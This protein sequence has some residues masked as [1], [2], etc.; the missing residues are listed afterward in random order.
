ML[1]KFLLWFKWT[2]RPRY[3]GILFKL[4]YSGKR[5]K[6]GKN[7]KCDKM[8]ELLITQKGKLSI[9]DNVTFK[10]N[11]EIRV[12]NNAVIEIGS[13]I[14]IDRGVRL[15][16]TNDAKTKISDGTRIGCYSI[17]NGGD[18]ITIGKKI[19]ISG[20]V[21]LQTSQHNFEKTD[22]IQSQGYSHAPITLGDDVW[23]GSHVTVL[24]G[25]HLHKGSIIGSNAV[26][27]KS[28]DENNIVAGV[29]AKVI[30]TRNQ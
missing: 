3:K 24:P 14:K 2:F 1:L 6:I 27:T 11:V 5:V 22:D 20:F 19:L 15:L 13:N 21:Y 28:V 23:I 8:P 16:A 18:N 17:L 26:V 30:K 10:R 25:C 9:G 12:H 7:F 4:F 29:P